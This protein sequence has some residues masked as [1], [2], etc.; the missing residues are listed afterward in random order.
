MN[1]ATQ[2]FFRHSVPANQL[3]AEHPPRLS[4]PNKQAIHEV[5]C[6]RG[7]Q[8]T[9]HIHIT[10]WPPKMLPELMSP[11]ADCAMIVRK[12][13][14]DYEPLRPQS[15]EWH[16]NFADRH[17]FAAYGSGLF[18]QDEIQVA[19]HPALASV[20]EALLALGLPPL[21]SECNRPT[22]IL[23]SG[24]QRRCRVS[25][26]PDADRG[27]PAGLYG[28][29]FAR[30]SADTVRQATQRID[31]PETSHILAMSAPTGGSGVYTRNEIHRILMTAF[32]G[33]SAAVEET[34]RL[35]PEATTAVHTGFW[36]CGAFGGNRVLMTLLQ[37]LAA[38]MVPLDALIFHT[39]DDAGME[40]YQE[41]LTWLHALACEARGAVPTEKTIDRIHKLGFRWGICDGN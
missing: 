24:A 20:L 11:A 5:A 19:E 1:I 12:A 13:I 14:Y 23:V 3:V 18:A 26:E 32:T 15:M 9:G 16:V 7:T 25:I 35:K 6:P 29:A 36:G 4:H 28:C 39:V 2:P 30:A 27:R 33:F 37:I 8:H 17:L 40:S 21:T 10:R 38:R 22:P 31:P 41:A 34:A